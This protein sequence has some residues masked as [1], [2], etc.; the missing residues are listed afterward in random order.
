MKKDWM[1]LKNIEYARICCY[2]LILTKYLYEGKARAIPSG[3]YRAEVTCRQVPF[4]SYLCHV[5]V[6]FCFLKI[7]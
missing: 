1:V 5:L 3:S 2:N 4:S 6:D 7:Y